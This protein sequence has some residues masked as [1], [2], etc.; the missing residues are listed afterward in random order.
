MPTSKNISLLGGTSRIET[1][2]IKITIGDYTFGV[3]QKIDATKT[4]ASGFY[5]QAQI[6]Y[7]NYVKSLSVSKLNGQVN[8]YTLNLEFPITQTTDPNFFEK[9]FSSVSQTRKILFSYGDMSLPAYVY[10]NEEAMITKIS[11]QFDI[12]NSKINYTVMAISS[13]TLL[14]SG[15]H[16][17]IYQGRHKPSDII[18][19]LLYANNDY[20][21]LQQVFY[22]MV[23]RNLVEQSGLIL[24]DDMAVPIAAQENV[25]VLEFLSYLVSIMTPAG[26]SQG[27][28]KNRDFYSW[29][30]VDDTSGEFG[31]PYFK[32]VKTTQGID[33]SEAYEIDVG[34]PTANVITNFSIQDNESYS[35]L[36]DFQGKLNPS[37]Y[38]YKINNKGELEPNF[39]PVISS[40][41]DTHTTR[42]EDKVW[43]SKVT[44][45]PIKA[46]ITLKG[47]LRPAILMTYVRLNIY[48]YGNKYIDSGLYVVTQQQDDIN[49][50]G[51]RTTLSLTRI[52]GAEY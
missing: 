6:I 49:E 29:F 9:V 10:K 45:F 36:Y 27:T 8:Q 7:P 35:L 1:P 40:H 38:S 52:S 42:P 31:G 50:G 39:A 32:I 37:E 4:D 24:G 16:S 43:W 34:Y 21:G 3:Y 30:I 15:N 17:F 22:G 28:I 19:Q 25:S 11:K 2:Y 18:K 44:E 5:K 23:N 48:F 26:S 47:L 20:Y 33:N 12:V 46:T 41:N 51:Y 13:A 14:A